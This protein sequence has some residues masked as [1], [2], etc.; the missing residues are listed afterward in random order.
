MRLWHEHVDTRC[1]RNDESYRCNAKLNETINCGMIRKEQSGERIC[2]IKEMCRLN[3]L[4]SVTADLTLTLLLLTWRNL[5]SL[6][7]RIVAVKDNPSTL[8]NN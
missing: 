3:E 5:P 1:C 4:F 7:R 2:F 6:T 8:S